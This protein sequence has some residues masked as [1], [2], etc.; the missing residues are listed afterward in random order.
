[1]ALFVFFIF[2]IMDEQ[3]FKTETTGLKCGPPPLIGEL[4][5][6]FILTLPMI[7]VQ[8]I[9]NRVFSISGKKNKE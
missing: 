1:M 3:I 4:S 9:L 7:L 5:V 8:Y 6:I 2:A